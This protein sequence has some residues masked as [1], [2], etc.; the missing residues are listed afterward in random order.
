MAGYLRLEYAGAGYHVTARG[1]DRTPTFHGEADRRHL[2]AMLTDMLERDEVRSTFAVKSVAR[3]CGRSGMGWGSRVP[4]C[5]G[6]PNVF[7][8]G[9]PRRQA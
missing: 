8:N 3:P 6:Q 9:W 1:N 7:A 4:R 5:A 2:L